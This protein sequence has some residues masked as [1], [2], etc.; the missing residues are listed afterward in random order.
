[1]LF[2]GCMLSILAVIVTACSSPTIVCGGLQF[3]RQTL[4]DTTTIKVGAATI[5]IAGDS[6]DT[7][8]G[9]PAHQYVWNVSDSSV[10][11]VAPIDSVHARITGLRSGRATVTPV[12][13][14]GGDA[15]SAI[16]VTVVP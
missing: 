4:P 1:M 6:Y 7:C 16:A 3:Q 11:K 15:L 2:R 8:A 9:P 10:V 13:A 5:A 12:Y 14:A